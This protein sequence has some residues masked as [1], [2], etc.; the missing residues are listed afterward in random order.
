MED[1]KVE[2][3]SLYD[4]N[5]EKIY[6]FSLLKVGSKEAAEEITSE[7]FLKAWKF[8]KKQGTINRVE[9]TQAFLYKI[10]GNIVIDYYRKSAKI[11]TVSIDKFDLPDSIDIHENAEIKSDFD[12]VRAVLATMKEDYQQVI[13]CRHIE[14]MDI[15]EIS[16]IMNKSEGAT[17]AILH[18][19]LTEL[20]SKFGDIDEA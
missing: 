10:A 12:N 19:A 20:K 6:R 3:S 7:T 15:P 18:R 14:G 17:R 9:N 16:K 11:K 5:V 2:F 8:F 13:I 4:N 1:L